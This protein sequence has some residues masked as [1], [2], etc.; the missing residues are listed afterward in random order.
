VARRREKERACRL[1]VD[2]AEENR[3]FAS[4]GEDNTETGPK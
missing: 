1:L 2:K 3:P 4:I